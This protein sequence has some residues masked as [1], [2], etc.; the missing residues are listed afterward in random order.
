M[1]EIYMD[2]AGKYRFRLKGKNGGRPMLSSTG[3]WETVEEVKDFI[4]DV[5][6]TVGGFEVDF[7]LDVNNQSYI[8]FVVHKED[9]TID[10]VA[11][12]ESYY[13]KSNTNRALKS[14]TKYILNSKTKVID[15]T[16]DAVLEPLFKDK[17][18]RKHKKN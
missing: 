16:E 7:R 17:Q 15:L 2:E 6:C 14:I 10:D 18:K 4:N 13:S 12:T 1:F 5:I 3:S 9:G 8:V 11:K